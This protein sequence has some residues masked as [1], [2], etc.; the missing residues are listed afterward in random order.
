VADGRR[1]WAAA[2]HAHLRPTFI[3]GCSSRQKGPFLVS[4]WCGIDRFTHSGRRVMSTRF[5]SRDDHF[6]H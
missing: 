2:V 6:R 4:I 5:T 3:T 1:E